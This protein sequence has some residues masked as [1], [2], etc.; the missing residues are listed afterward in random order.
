MNVNK[1]LAI[2]EH[3]ICHPGL[4]APGP[5]GL[6]HHGSPGLD[7]FHRAKSIADLLS[8]TTESSCGRL[9]KSFP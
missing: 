4:P 8:V 6:G 2:V 9:G 3:S 1:H 7:P 5:Q